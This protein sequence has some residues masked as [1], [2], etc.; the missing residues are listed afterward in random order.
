M[1]LNMPTYTIKQ[2]CEELQV[3]R[4]TLFKWIKSGRIRA[5]KLS[6]RAVRI[7]K[8]ELERFKAEATTASVS[9]GESTPEA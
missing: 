5:I 9:A 7:D 2:A 1:Y 4:T 8:E 6:P 3:C